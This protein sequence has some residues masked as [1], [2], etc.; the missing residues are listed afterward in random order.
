MSDPGTAWHPKRLFGKFRDLPDL[1]DDE[2]TEHMRKPEADLRLL[3][4]EQV[5][6]TD[7]T[8]ER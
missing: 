2:V 1:T 8:E 4:A 7:V 3:E 6:G 5:L